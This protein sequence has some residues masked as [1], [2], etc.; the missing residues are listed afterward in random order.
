MT[1]DH[2]RDNNGMCN[3]CR[4]AVRPVR[5]WNW[6]SVDE[7]IEHLLLD[8]GYNAMWLNQEQDLDLEDDADAA[9]WW[10]DQAID[11]RDSMH[12]DDHAQY[13]HGGGDTVHNH[14]LV[15]KR[16]IEAAIESIKR[17]VNK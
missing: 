17:V 12:E 14:D 9:R 5:G 11:Y 2:S 16:E 13:D 8:H 6:M 3:E 4:V 15:D 10:K 1:E 7:Q